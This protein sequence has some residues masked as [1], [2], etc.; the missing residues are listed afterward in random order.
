MLAT[1]YEIGELH[2]RVFGTNGFHIKAKNERFTAASSRCRQNLKYANFTSSF[3]RLRQKLH[4]KA[5]RTCSTNIF[6]YSTNQIM[7][8]RRC[9]CRCR[10]HFL[11]SLFSCED[12]IL[13]VKRIDRPNRLTQCCTQFKS[14]GVKILCVCC[15]CI[16]MSHSHLNDMEIP[17]TKR[18]IPKG[19]EL[20]TTLS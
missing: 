12:G 3:G 2:F 4:Q 13:V 8:L 20:G 16:R 15:I 14:P 18:F 10:S 11:N 7:D 1:L 6:P 9:G 17:E 19:F 5:C